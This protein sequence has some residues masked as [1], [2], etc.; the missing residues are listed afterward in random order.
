MGWWKP[1]IKNCEFGKEGSNLVSDTERM[2]IFLDII[3]Q[4]LSNLFRIEFMLI[5]EKIMFLGFSIL[6]YPKRETLLVLLAEAKLVVL[7]AR[8]SLKL[9]NQFGLKACENFFTNW[10]VSLLFKAC[11]HY[12]LSNF[13]FFTKW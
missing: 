7:S 1:G 4:S 6:K 8:L 2:S 10:A 9:H 12:F 3:S 13:C 11:V 5:K